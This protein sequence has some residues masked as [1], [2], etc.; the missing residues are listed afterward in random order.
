MP[1]L[2]YNPELAGRFDLKRLEYEI[3]K[4]PENIEEIVAYL[5]LCESQLKLIDATGF[6]TIVKVERHKSYDYPT[7]GN[8]TF[9][10]VEKRIP[11]IE[12]CN[13]DEYDYTPRDLFQWKGKEWDM[14]LRHLGFVSKELATFTGKERVKAIKF[15]KEH[16]AKVNGDAVYGRGY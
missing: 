9:T 2:N 11:I 1:S 13:Y 10:V 5:D 15:A 4:A 14:K 12:G 3:E 7:Y 6:K 8:I 16:A